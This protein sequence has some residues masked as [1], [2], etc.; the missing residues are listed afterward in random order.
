[1][2]KTVEDFAKEYAKDYGRQCRMEGRIEGHKEGRIEGHKEGR[3][4]MIA[5]ML[6]S[7]KTPEEIAA[8]TGIALEE[9][10]EVETSLYANV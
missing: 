1:M 8:F 5:G 3:K 7:G 10:A 9:I 6:S 2:C 4:E